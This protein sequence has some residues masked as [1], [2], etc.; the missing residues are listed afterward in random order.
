M[1]RVEQAVEFGLG[2]VEFHSVAVGDGFPV[3]GTGPQRRLDG[4]HQLQQSPGLRE[5]GGGR[6]A[7]DEQ[8][9]HAVQAQ[10]DI[11]QCHHARIGGDIREI[12]LAVDVPE[13]V[14]GQLIFRIKVE[15]RR[16]DCSAR[17]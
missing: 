10:V 6:F 14:A 16:N 15:P 13:A 3:I 5:L 7:G 12:K 8:R 4:Q 2:L 1:F 11:D 9:G 17:A